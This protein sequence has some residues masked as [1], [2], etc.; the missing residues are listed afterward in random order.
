MVSATSKKLSQEGRRLANLHAAEGPAASP[1]VDP[2]TQRRRIALVAHDS[3]KEKLAGWVRRQRTRLIQHELFA[4]A[5]TADVITATLNVP[6]FRLLSG[7][8]GGDQQIGCRIAESRID[9]L[10]F[11]W[12]PFGIHPHDCDVKA[13][14]RLAAAY[15]IP[16][17]CNEATADCI[18][19]TLTEV[20]SG[21]KGNGVE[22]KGQVNR[23]SR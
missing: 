18:I 9:M 21:N 23:G 5:H 4:T 16:N 13:L 14:L 19:S 11:F 15:N 12:D 1:A 20:S 2:I 7:P 8:L 10:V 3:Q 17:A 6:V 22:A